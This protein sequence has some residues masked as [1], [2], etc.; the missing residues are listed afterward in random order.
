GNIGP[1]RENDNLPEIDIVDP[2]ARQ[3]VVSKPFPAATL[4][5]TTALEA[6]DQV[7]EDAGASKGLNCDGTFFLRRDAIDSRI[8]DEVLNGTGGIIDDPSQVGGWL[9]IP[10]AVACTDSDRDG[11]PDVWEQKH[12]FNSNDASDATED[13]D[14]NGYTNIEEFLNGTSLLP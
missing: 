14:G 1:Q 12:G 13:A 5:T 10:S 9:T 11:M 6:Y 4:I 7:L 8:V 3:F 2:D